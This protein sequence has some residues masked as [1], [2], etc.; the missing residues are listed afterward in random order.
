MLKLNKDK[1]SLLLCML[2]GDGCLYKSAKK[3]TGT[4]RVAHGDSQHDYIEW[5]RQLLSEIVGT[6]VKL[7]T[8]YV[9]VDGKV[10][11][12][13]RVT[14]GMKR[15]VAWRKF[16][17]PNGKKD[18]SKII[19]F[20][21][22]PELALAIWLG[23]DGTVNFNKKTHSISLRIHTDSESLESVDKLIKWLDINFNVSSK[24]YMRKQRGKR[25][26]TIRFNTSDSLK[27]YEITKDFFNRFKSMKHKFREL[28]N[29]YQCKLQQRQLSV[30]INAQ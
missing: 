9:R 1:R 19:R 18:A 8:V 7:S 6:E 16:F 5:K 30:L 3:R 14:K 26:P 23:D 20:I 4:F 11:P 22:H 12:S 2:I 29:K 21:R 13:H 27:I 28:E 15:F 25:Y 17:Y 10:F 24:I